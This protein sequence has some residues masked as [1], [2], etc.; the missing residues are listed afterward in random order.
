MAP[1]LTWEDQADLA[2]KSRDSPG[3]TQAIYSE[4]HLA[5]AIQA[6]PRTNHPISNEFES[7]H[8]CHQ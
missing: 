7:M 6:A 4:T 1:T 2:V 5:K 8:V 3:L